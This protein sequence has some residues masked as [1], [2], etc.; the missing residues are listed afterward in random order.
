MVVPASETK[1]AGEGKVLDRRVRSL[2]PGHVGLGWFKGP[3]MGQS[4]RR[5]K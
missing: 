1:E 5:V 2:S 4:R 3:K